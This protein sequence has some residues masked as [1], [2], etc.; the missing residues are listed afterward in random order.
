[1]RIQKGTIILTITH[2]EFPKIRGITFLGGPENRECNTLKSIPTLYSLNPNIG[3][4][5][6]MNPKR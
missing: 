6:F 4:P 3:V 1:M 2:M 5:Q